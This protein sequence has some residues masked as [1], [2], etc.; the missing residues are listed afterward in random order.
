MLQ[1]FPRALGQ[2]DHLLDI[3]QRTV[4]ALRIGCFPLPCLK[5]FPPVL[6]SAYPTPLAPHRCPAGHPLLAHAAGRPGRPSGER[7]EHRRAGGEWRR[8]G[9]G[10][11]R[12]RTY[13][14]LTGAAEFQ[15]P[16]TLSLLVCAVHV[17]HP[18]L[19]LPR[20]AGGGGRHGAAA[21]VLLPVQHAVAGGEGEEVLMSKGKAPTPH[22][23]G[24]LL[25]LQFS[26]YMSADRSSTGG[27]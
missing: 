4:R 17:D 9:R 3:L 23:W 14:G 15:Q 19:L 12:R 1:P 21:R 5:P 2:P 20:R 26:G 7:G 6:Q 18:R 22:V 16:M 11:R 24:A 25:P 10:R 8:R 27:T 13:R